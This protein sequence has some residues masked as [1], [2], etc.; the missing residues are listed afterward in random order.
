MKIGGSA[1]RTP[2]RRAGMSPASG[3]SQIT[4]GWMQGIATQDIGAVLVNSALAM[5]LHLRGIPC[6]HASGVGRNVRSPTPKRSAA[7]VPERSCATINSTYR[8]LLTCL[9]DVIDSNR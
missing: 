7:K 8:V 6:L 3:A 9:Y 1:R 4:V 2:Q 5:A